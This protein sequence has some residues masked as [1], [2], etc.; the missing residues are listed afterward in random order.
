MDD[1]EEIIYRQVVDEG[2]TVIFEGIRVHGAHNRWID[3]VLRNKGVI[4]KDEYRF[5]IL[6]TTPEQSRAYMLARRAAVG[7]DKPLSP[8][9]LDSIED[10]YRRGRRQLRHFASE[11][12]WVKDVSSQEAVDL[13]LEWDA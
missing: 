10:H 8:A 13:I 7:S 1:V 5:L 2:R 3:F 9:T 11:R 4:A 12:L 6:N